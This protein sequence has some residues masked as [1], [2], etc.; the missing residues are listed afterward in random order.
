M[1]T[2]DEHGTDAAA[3]GVRDLRLGQ[4]HSVLGRRDLSK[5]PRPATAPTTS[6]VHLGDLVLVDRGALRLGDVCAV[7]A[8]TS[9]HAFVVAA[10]HDLGLAVAAWT[11]WV[12]RE[13][14][15]AHHP[16][17]RDRANAQYAVPLATA[18]HVPHACARR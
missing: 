5:R 17:P 4:R 8:R 10:E 7:P 13:L 9:A 15:S 16:L 12:H 6:A 1:S 14:L 3:D 18:D 2:I 11:Y